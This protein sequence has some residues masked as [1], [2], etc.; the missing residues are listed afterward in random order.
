MN[1]IKCPVCGNQLKVNEVTGIATCDGCGTAI[2]VA[3]HIVN[4]TINNNYTQHIINDAK[5]RKGD[6]DIERSKA[7]VRKAEIEK[8][9]KETKYA[10]IAISIF[11]VLAIA[12][13]ITMVMIPK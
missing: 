3:D 4:K 2:K 1:Q 8:D 6:A 13:A 5:V 12:F 9:K 11:F 10:F 7:E